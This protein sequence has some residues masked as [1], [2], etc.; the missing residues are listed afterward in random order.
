VRWGLWPGDGII[1]SGE[2]S[3]VER[4]GLRPMDAEQAVEAGL[5]DYPADP[6]VFTADAER[7]RTFL[8]IADEKRAE[9]A[10]DSAEPSGSETTDAS[11][12]TGAMRIALAAVLKLADTTG[13]DFDT[14]LLDLGVDSLLAIDLRKKLKKA[15]GRSVPLATIL[16]GATATELIEQ[17]EK[18]EKETFTRD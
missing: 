17:L 15:T 14:S 5:R 16:G 2:I 4:S 10:G 8:G 11:D 7:L 3:R 6:L 9:C 12:A 18:P 13:L 1:D